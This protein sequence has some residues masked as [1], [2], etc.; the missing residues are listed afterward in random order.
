MYNFNTQSG[1]TNTVKKTTD[2]SVGAGKEVGPKVNAEK[3][4]WMLHFVTRLQE[5]VIIQEI[6][7]KSFTEVADFK[8]FVTAVTNENNLTK[9]SRNI[10]ELFTLIWSVFMSPRIKNS[11]FG[12]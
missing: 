2:T 4:V 11:D 5:S 1:N 8:Y 6:Q 3:T 7:D 10:K 12:L 9:K